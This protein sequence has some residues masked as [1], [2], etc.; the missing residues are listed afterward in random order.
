MSANSV[1]QN[2]F[3][4]QANISALWLSLQSALNDDQQHWMIQAISQLSKPDQDPEAL[5][6]HLVSFTAMMKRLLGENR[7]PLRLPTHSPV[8]ADSEEKLELNHWS[9][10]DIGRA[11]LL[12]SALRHCEY[13]HYRLIQ[14][15]YTYSDNSEKKSIVL[16]L[17]WLSDD[18]RVAELCEEV[19]RTNAMDLFIALALNNPIPAVYY[20]NSAFNQL[21]LKSLFQNMQ[22]DQIL[23]LRCRLNPELERMCDDYLHERRLANRDI[24][25]SLWL[26]LNPN[27]ASQETTEAWIA[28]LNSDSAEQRFYAISALLACRHSGQTIPRPLQKTLTRQVLIDTDPAILALVQDMQSVI[29]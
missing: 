4:L 3:S 9:T 16:S 26:T 1:Q 7:L 23:G 27:T 19:Q 28:A 12:G 21:V 20:S 29:H 8:I 10:A 17:Y 24:P 13:D 5:T 25:A 18:K 11:V 14:Q 2:P 22:I 6:N 15:A